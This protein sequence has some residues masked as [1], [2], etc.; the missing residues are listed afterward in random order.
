MTTQ[1]E[2]IVDFDK[3]RI[4]WGQPDDAYPPV[5]F[6]L[7]IR[8]LAIEVIVHG[9]ATLQRSEIRAHL[10]RGLKYFIRDQQ[11]HQYVQY[12]KTILYRMANYSHL[13]VDEWANR[14]AGTFDDKSNYNIWSNIAKPH[15]MLVM[16]ANHRTSIVTNRKALDIGKPVGMEFVKSE[17]G[18]V[19]NHHSLGLNAQTHQAEA[20]LKIRRDMARRTR[21]GGQF[22][23]FG[24]LELREAQGL[25]ELWVGEDHLWSIDPNN[26]DA[27][28]IPN[29]EYFSDWEAGFA[30]SDP[31]ACRY[32]ALYTANQLNLIA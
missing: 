18:V 25:V 17:G 8:Q 23:S 6:L 7:N 19:F 10:Q 3:P 26:V 16:D 1:T 22:S 4:V 32:M 21:G 28:I 14:V 13:D 12:K 30:M 31:S 20:G 11:L 15:E 29:T 9:P 5:E 27:G 2:V 24:I